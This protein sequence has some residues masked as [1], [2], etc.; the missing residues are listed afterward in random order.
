MQKLGASEL[1]AY[2]LYLQQ[3][4]RWADSPNI[5]KATGKLSPYSIQGHVRAIKA[6]W[7]WAEREGHIK[8]NPLAK[9]PLPKVPQKLLP[10]L[11][12]GEIKNVL[13][14]L[15]RHTPIGGKYYLIIL[16]LTDTGIRISELSHIKIHDLDLQHNRVKILGKGQK[17]RIVPFSPVTRSAIDRYLTTSRRHLCSVDSPY[18]FPRPNG[19]PVSINSVQQFLRRIGARAILNGTRCSPHTFRHSF[20]TMA[21]ANGANV[22]VL[23]EIMGHESLQTTMKYVHLQPDDLQLQHTKFSPVTN[24]GIGRR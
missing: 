10:T 17:W 15:D 19:L 16:L 24:L 4:K 22:M 7:S 2:I 18:L 20:A 14:M 23:K 11:S 1:K 6:F 13:S 5:K 8:A 3:K 9:F 12:R 21:V